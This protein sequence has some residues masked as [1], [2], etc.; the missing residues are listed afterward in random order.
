MLFSSPEDDCWNSSIREATTDFFQIL[1]N[2]SFA[3]FLSFYH[4][5]ILASLNTLTVHN[6]PTIS[7]YWLKMHYLVK[8]LAP[9]CELLKLHGAERQMYV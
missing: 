3:L 6:A 7:G 1:S 9:L 2:P 8:Y 5:I 4:Q